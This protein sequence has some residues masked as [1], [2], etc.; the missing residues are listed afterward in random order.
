MKRITAAATL[1]ALNALNSVATASEVNMNPGL[2]KWTAVMDMPGMPMQL[3]PTS[4]T[5]CITSA[6]FVPKERTPG[7]SC[8]TID[9]K[10]AGDKVSWNITCTQQ[11]GVTTSQGEITYHGDTAEGVIHITAQGMQMTS[12]TTGERLG[13]CQK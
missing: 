7:Q 12:R 13:A 1:L 11:G 8:E 9:L 2:W 3:P 6:D 5:T 10:T 4:Y